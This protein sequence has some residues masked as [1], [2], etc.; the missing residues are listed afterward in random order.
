MPFDI[1]PLFVFIDV[2]ITMRHVY[3]SASIRYAAAADYFDTLFSR[4][5]H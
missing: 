1:T 4:R 5:C 3:F 2:F